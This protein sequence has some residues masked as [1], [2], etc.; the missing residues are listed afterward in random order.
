MARHSEDRRKL[1]QQMLA[2]K[3]IRGERPSIPKWEGPGDPPLSRNQQRLWYLDRLE[4]GTSLYNDCVTVRFHG[5]LDASA[6]TAAFAE[7][8]RRHA[9]LRSSFAIS[10][11]RPVQRFAEA[12]P[13]EVRCADLRHLGEGAAAA[14][15]AELRADVRT[16]F[17]L[18]RPPLWRASLLRTADDRWEFGLTMHHIVSDGASYGVVYAE[19]SALY[20]ALRAG[21]PSPLPELSV[22]IGDYAAW[23]CARLADDLIESKLAYWRQKLAPPLPVLALPLDNPRSGAGRH[24]GAF[25]RFAVDGALFR[26]LGE[27]CRREAVTSY[28]VLLT[29]WV[30]VLHRLSGQED[31]V[32][33]TPSSCRTHPDLEKLVGFFIKTVVVR[34][35]L[36]GNPTLRE[37]LARTQRTALE[38]Q[39]HDDAPFDRIVQEVRGERASAKVPLLQAWFTHMRDMIPPPVLP[40]LTASYEIVDPKNARF[41]LA[42]IMDETQDGI[43]AYFEY[44]VDLFM[45]AT[46]ARV[47]DECLAVLQHLLR[48]PDTTLRSLR[49]AMLDRT[50]APGATAAAAVPARLGTMKKRSHKD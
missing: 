31:V 29:C 50:R 6:F 45:P 19:L 17:D 11:A 36:R 44:D 46:I 27:F 37:L 12:L 13:A 34:M 24:R 48:H 8:V 21:A 15:E 4:P 16:P 49:E 14:A 1:L 39:E 25:H 10:D 2:C 43:A 26:A 33:G 35:D 38:A 40:G 20:P 47:G 18:T 30:A 7:I 42:L 3:G 5:A 41:E 9:S 28:W 32:V 23:D 22:Q